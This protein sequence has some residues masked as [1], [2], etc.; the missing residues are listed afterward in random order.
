MD[1]Q[2][3]P[4]S[5]SLDLLTAWLEHGDTSDGSFASDLHLWANA[6]WL[7]PPDADGEP[8]TI[9]GLLTEEADD[10]DAI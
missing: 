2:M 9:Y 4:V 5:V 7:P 1:S 3:Q 10:L 6:E 8:S